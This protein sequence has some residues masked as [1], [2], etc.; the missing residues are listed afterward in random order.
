[1]RTLHNSCISHCI[2]FNASKS[3][4]WPLSHIYMA[5]NLHKKNSIFKKQNVGE[6]QN[7]DEHHKKTDEIV[8]P[9]T[10]LS[11]VSLLY[12]HHNSKV[13]SSK[14]EERVLR[15]ILAHKSKFKRLL[16]KKGGACPI[17]HRR[18]H[19]GIPTSPH[20]KKRSVSYVS[21]SHTRQNFD[22]SSSKKHT[23]RP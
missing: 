22:I 3:Y 21:S 4:S 1:M 18:T 12:T 8:I 15:L 6:H 17:S 16:I 11:Y 14:K 23:T 2:S 20:R 9:M 5:I 19:I 7:S 10:F 13:S